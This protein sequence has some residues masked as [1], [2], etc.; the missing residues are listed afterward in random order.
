[1]ILIKK[2]VFGQTAVCAPVL[3]S[4]DMDKVKYAIASFGFILKVG[5]EYTGDQFAALIKQHYDNEKADFLAQLLKRVHSIRDH[6]VYVV[7]E[8]IKKNENHKPAL[9]KAHNKI[10]SLVQDGFKSGYARAFPFTFVTSEGKNAIGFVFGDSKDD[11]YGLVDCLDEFRKPFGIDSGPVTFLHAGMT[12]FT[13][14]LNITD[15]FYNS[16][17]LNYLKFE[18]AV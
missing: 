15:F 8:D 10:N 3:Q 12:S 9:L 5:V 18:E 17:T 13:A 2:N 7:A 6:F 16:P 1:M 14:R 11:A 4:D